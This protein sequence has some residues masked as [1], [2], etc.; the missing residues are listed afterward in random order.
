[1]I[2]GW[3]AAGTCGVV[4]CSALKRSYR[5][6]LLTDP[7]EVLLVYMRGTKDVVHERMAARHEHFMPLALLDSQ[8]A[9]LEEPGPDEHPVVLSI[10]QPP[11]ATV[12][13]LIRKLAELRPA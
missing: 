8:F 12:N 13:V 3:R 1:M 7:H 9:T 5:A 11:A 10:E 2:D 6:M 4:S